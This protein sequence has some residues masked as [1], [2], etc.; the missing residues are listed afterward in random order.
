MSTY[1]DV[2]AAL[3]L[4]AVFASDIGRDS[5]PISCLMPYCL[6]EIDITSACAD[7]I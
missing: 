3:S 2:N 4:S 5:L 6:H 1:R 7:V